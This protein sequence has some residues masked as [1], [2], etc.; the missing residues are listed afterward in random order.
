MQAGNNLSQIDV[1]FFRKAAA[2]IFYKICLGFKRFFK[3]YKSLATFNLKLSHYVIG[4]CCKRSNMQ[5]IFFLC[6]EA[7]TTSKG[8]THTFSAEMLHE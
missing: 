1:K 2:F 6:L 3:G 5:L 8:V 4:K 7:L